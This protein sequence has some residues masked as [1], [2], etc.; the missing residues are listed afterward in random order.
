MVR[1]Q[2]AVV[3]LIRQ[4][5]LIVRVH[6]VREVNTGACRVQRENVGIQVEL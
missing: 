3:L 4:Q 5:H 1:R 6:A 2:L